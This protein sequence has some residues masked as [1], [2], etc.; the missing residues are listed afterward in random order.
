MVVIRKRKITSKFIENATQRKICHTN[1]VKGL[2][3][4][5]EQV[6]TLCGIEACAVVFGPGDLRPLVWPSRDVAKKLI[7]KFESMP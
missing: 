6:K 7:Q 3:T 1:R 5:M 4:K 2:F